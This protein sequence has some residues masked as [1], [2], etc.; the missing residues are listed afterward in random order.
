MKDTEKS[1]DEIIEEAMRG[2]HD[3]IKKNEESE[4]D[5]EFIDLDL[6]G[7]DFEK[8]IWNRKKDSDDEGFLD[9]DEFEGKDASDGGDEDFEE[10]FDKDYEEPEDLEYLDDSEEEE[11]S[12]EDSDYEDEPDYGEDEEP[13]DTESEDIELE[14]IELEDI[15][16]E[17]TLLE[18]IELEESEA[19]EAAD[20]EA[21]ED[22]KLRRHKMKKRIGIAAGSVTGVLAAV[23]IGFAVFF[24]SHFMFFTTINGTD[25]S[26]KSVEQVESYMKEQVA[27]YTLTLEESGGG[28]EEIKGT[29]ISLE[30]VPG[31]ELER[32]VKKQDNF[33]WIKSLWEKPKIEAAIGVKYNEEALTGQI[34]GLSCLIPENQTASVDAH[35]EFQETAFVVVPEVIGTQIDTEKLGSAVTES[36]N[37]FKP[38][39]DLSEAGCYIQPRFV[40]DSPEVVAAKDA[41]NSYLGANITYDFSPSTEVVDAAVISQWV[42]VDADMNVTFDEEAVRA[43][44]ASLA[45]KYDTAGKPREF[46]TANGNVVTVEGGTYGWE[47]DQETEYASL[48][49]NIQ[50]AETVTREPAYI[51][52][53]ASHDAMD[54]GN[55]YVEVDLTNQHMWY[56]QDGQVMMDSAVV[57][58]S[59]IIRGRAT[60]QGTYTILEMMRN[61]T[62]TGAIDP[63]TGEPEYRTPVAFWMR[64]TWSGVGFHDATWQ[65]SFGGTRYRNGY[66]SHGCINM[67]YGQASTLY[68]MLSVGTP[69][70]IHY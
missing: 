22:K 31:K 38:S 69:V 14:D 9:E 53:A 40:E 8:N 30:Y 44:I 29:D 66:G 48:I 52:R 46:T 41:M 32:L 19:E 33:L 25:F 27:G 65:S 34:A 62:L 7:E 36:I 21:E 13:E 54:V 50:N 67:P 60:P 5:I 49:A 70:V 6:E 43:Y 63:S 3:D 56:I 17:D 16:L 58:G 28:T 1:V 12:A 59:T 2:I 35:P 4:A 37:G 23:Y 26:M 42:K 57:T 51:S 39:V 68:S 61:K 20:I 47:I 64:V 11:D 45:E 15:E 55:T 24:G 18:D 10:L